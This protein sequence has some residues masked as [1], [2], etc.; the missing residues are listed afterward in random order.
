[1]P[2]Q[3]TPSDPSA[4]LSGASS[5]LES[6]AD[7]LDRLFE[8][9]RTSLLAAGISLESSDASLE[10]SV[11]SATSGINSLAALRQDLVAAKAEVRRHNLAAGLWRAGALS[12][13]AGLAGS[14]LDRSNPRGAAIGAGAGALAGGVW[15][16]TEHWPPWPF[17]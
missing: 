12:G 15:L 17:N 9:L 2:G 14:L 1:M 8:G 11:I 6:T 3:P 5:E 7:R 16:L 13:I 4:T 10:S